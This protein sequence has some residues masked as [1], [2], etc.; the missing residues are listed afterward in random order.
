MKKLFFFLAVSFLIIS[1]RNNE[2]PAQ[3]TTVNLNHT[4]SIT[5]VFLPII[6][7]EWIPSDY[8]ENL[9]KTLSAFQAYTMNNGDQ[10][11]YI[12]PTEL[13]GDSLSIAFFAWRWRP[14]AIHFVFQER[15]KRKFLCA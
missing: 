4:D 5:K 14:G 11:I 12:N 7:G 9:K 8:I 2:Q 10:G 15:K 6:T 3:N 1:C 13:K